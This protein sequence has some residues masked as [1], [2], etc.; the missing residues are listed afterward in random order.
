MA[1]RFSQ[2]FGGKR[3]VGEPR[4]SAKETEPAPAGRK[5]L[6]HRVPRPCRTKRFGLRPGLNEKNKGGG[7][8]FPARSASPWEPTPVAVGG[9]R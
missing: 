9:Q 5:V 4:A 1:E 8:G 6:F 3:C 7:T 2:L